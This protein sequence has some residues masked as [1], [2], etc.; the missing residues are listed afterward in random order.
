MITVDRIEW[1]MFITYSANRILLAQLVAN[2][3]EHK[4]LRKLWKKWY[5]T[6]IAKSGL[7]LRL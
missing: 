6:L 3:S 7:L 4:R 1:R 2:C 5:S